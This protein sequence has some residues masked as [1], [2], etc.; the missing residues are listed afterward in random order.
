MLP[1]QPA[2]RNTTL[3][4]RS[5]FC[6]IGVFTTMLAL[7]ACGVAPSSAGI[8]VPTQDA[9]PTSLAMITQEL[10][11]T[12]SPLVPITTTSRRPLLGKLFS[13]HGGAT[14]FVDVLAHDGNTTTPLRLRFDA[15]KDERCPRLVACVVRG[16][17]VLAIVAQI[18]QDSQAQTVQLHTDPSLD[19]RHAIY[20]GYDISLVGLEPT[21]D[22]PGDTIALNDYIAHLI[23]SSVAPLPP[24]VV[25][26]PSATPTPPS[27][28]DACVL[29]DTTITNRVGAIQSA[30]ASSRLPDYNGQQCVIQAER[31]AVTLRFYR[32]DTVTAQTIIANAQQ[33]GTHFSEFSNTTGSVSAFGEIQQQAVLV[34]Q[35]NDAIFL[36]ELAF[37]EQS[38]PSDH[39]EA[40]ANLDAL[41]TMVLLRY[42]GVLSG[43]ITLPTAQPAP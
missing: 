31:A 13:V 3:F 14:M 8:S 30:P 28:F 41:Q 23:V 43:Q 11:A 4:A 15:V 38:Q 17:A 35:S 2:W 39:N 10:T 26:V 36:I 19:Q 16:D 33:A 40:R 32:G 6:K 27:A 18:G 42:V 29:V 5:C 20:E 34:K 7:A 24:T 37:N 1:N 25:P 9:A 22:R 12:L 21:V